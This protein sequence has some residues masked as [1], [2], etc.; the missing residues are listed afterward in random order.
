MNPIAFYIRLCTPRDTEFDDG[1]HPQEQIVLVFGFF[2]ILISLYSFLKWNSY[3]VSPLVLSSLFLLGM[4]LLTAGLV[5]AR[6][7]T[8]IAIN[9]TLLGFAVHAIN[10]V[11]QTGGMASPHILWLIAL[12]VGTY[13]MADAR[14]ALAWAVVFLLALVAMIA[15]ST[16]GTALPTLALDERALRVETWSGFLLPM[17][18]VWVM[19]VLSQRI[20]QQAMAITTA[21]LAEA[22]TSADAAQTNAEQLATVIAQAESSVDAL[23]EGG[24]N[25]GALQTTVQAHS[26]SIQQQTEQL[27]EAASFFNERLQQVSASLNEGNDLVQAINTEANTASADSAASA[28][29]MA[30][31]VS[32]MD[33]IKSNNDRIEIATGLINDIAQ[34]TNLLALNAAIEAARAGEAGRGFAVVADEVRNLSQKSDTSANEI[35]TLLSQSIADIDNGIE[36]VNVAQTTLT[37]VLDAVTRIS[38]SIAAVSAQ[39]VAQNQEVADMARSS[40]ELSQISQQQTDAAQALCDSQQALKQQAEELTKLSS[41]M[42]ATLH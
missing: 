33:Q 26:Q 35:R 27:T 36:V 6:A 29:A 10:M 23:S 25:L 24:T 8:V 37:R 18:M 42:Q 16:S 17:V 30:A 28:E 34:Q 20:R 41:A 1:Q 40:S 21:A 7:A 31:V 11:W 38:Q 19:Q 2:G 39:I 32:S 9:V 22:K 4:M 5:K 14:S 12:L 15:Q 13:F 3:G